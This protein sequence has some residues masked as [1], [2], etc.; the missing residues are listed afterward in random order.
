MILTHG[1]NSIGGGGSILPE[2]YQQLKY[3]HFQGTTSSYLYTPYGV[4]NTYR[5]ELK[6]KVH[7]FT[8]SGSLLFISS[9]CS[10][11][12]QSSSQ[13]IKV[14]NTNLS[15]L[16]YQD[17][18]DKSILLD[19]FTMILDKTQFIVNNESPIE[20]WHYASTAGQLTFGSAANASNNFDL[21]SIKFINTND[22]TTAL[23]FI[24][25]KELST[26]RYG[27]YEIIFNGFTLGTNVAP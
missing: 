7:S 22:G 1:A 10:I 12:A 4:P 20:L 13:Y 26:G 5:I 8:S 21:Y 11:I 2:G 3:I 27:L 19:D 14:R 23:H 25:C 17:T 16:G 6:G 18:Y 24:P 15:L 9:D